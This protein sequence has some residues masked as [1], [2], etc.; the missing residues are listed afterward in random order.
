MVKIAVVLIV[1]VLSVTV[2]CPFKLTEGFVGLD[3]EIGAPP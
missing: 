2:L 3:D 1:G